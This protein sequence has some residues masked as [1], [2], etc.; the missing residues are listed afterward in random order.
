MR[1][2]HVSPRSLG[3]PSIFGCRS[4]NLL[5]FTDGIPSLQQHRFCRG[6]AIVGFYVSLLIRL[7]DFGELLPAQC[8]AVRQHGRR[9]R[10]PERRH[11]AQGRMIRVAVSVF[12]AW[13]R[14]KT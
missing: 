12:T 8:W 3:L 10:I 13:M 6:A 7:A 5:G 4:W 2:G 11:S 1:H 9:D 14:M